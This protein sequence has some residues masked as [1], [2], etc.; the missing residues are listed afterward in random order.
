MKSGKRLL[1]LLLVALLASLTLW[2]PWG[3]PDPVGHE[4]SN[5]PGREAGAA[6]GLDRSEDQTEPLEPASRPAGVRE[7][8]ASAPGE[9]PPLAAV[10]KAWPRCQ[11][12]GRVV[13]SGAGL[14]G[15]AVKFWGMSDTW[16]D[17]PA[18]EGEI[19]AT[20]TITDGFGRFEFDL[21]LPTS[22]W[23]MITIDHMPY[24][25]RAQRSFRA[26]SEEEP[27]LVPGDDEPRLV[28]VAAGERDQ[29]LL[30]A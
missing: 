14:P 22:E 17:D 15:A 23:V 7:P 26:A 29:E 8:V 1:A 18:F 16:I 25:M 2:S 28:S 24:H 30:S 9:S 19:G 21:A 3:A 4:A 12:R 10:E 27:P 6:G 11:V 20:K 5:I 13:A